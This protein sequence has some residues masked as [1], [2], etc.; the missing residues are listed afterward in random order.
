[1][2]VLGAAFYV[3]ISFAS[4]CAAE[5]SKN[6]AYGPVFANDPAQ[7]TTSSSG[8]SEHGDAG[9]D[10]THGKP[11][12]AGA[13]AMDAAANDASNSDAG[14]DA[15]ADSSGDP[16]AMTDA[17]CSE[18]WVVVAGG[19]A[20]AGS[21]VL[22]G[23][24][25]SV[26][27]FTGKTLAG[28]PALERL[29][30][31]SLLAVGRSSD[32]ALWSARF[33]TTWSAPV[34]IGTVVARDLPALATLGAHA[35]LVYQDNASYTYFHGVWD[36]A[37]WDGA[38]DPVKAAGGG[39]SFGPRAPAALVL[40]GA[41]SIA[42]G[43]NA[44]GSLYIQGHDAAGW[45]AA[46]AV[47]GTAVCGNAE[48]GAPPAAVTLSGADDTLVVYIDKA[49]RGL[50]MAVR[51]TGA[52]WR[53]AGAVRPMAPIATTNEPFA[54]VRFDGDR[55]LVAFRGFDGFVYASVAGADLAW[56]A[57]TRLS[58]AATDGVPS[59]AAS[60]CGGDARVAFVQGGA[61]QIVN[62]RGVTFGAPEPVLGV[63]GVTHVALGVVR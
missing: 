16:D 21:A 31:G 36:G 9:E 25:W 38:T 42:H 2:R 32:G 51:S 34:R 8:S 35:H 39:Q 55:Y 1:M 60:S 18:R 22:A 33:G 15:G 37:S 50:S 46:A 57:P 45:L 7:G 27:S 3:A 11:K 48:C 13:T 26:A 56:S 49:T 52:V 43:G 54:L 10:G 63:G 4:G 59:V 62:Y 14:V 17:G 44:E 58:T 41:L 28:R 19:S 40:D 29:G 20:G 53:A 47:P 61:V 6:Q 30:D 24:A 12:D 5:G 23:G